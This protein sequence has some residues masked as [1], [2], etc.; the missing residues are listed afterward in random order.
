ML[1]GSAPVI[2]EIRIWKFLYLIHKAKGAVRN[3]DASQ[4]VERSS[5]FNQILSRGRMPGVI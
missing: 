2:S 1:L 5:I 4:K 3:V